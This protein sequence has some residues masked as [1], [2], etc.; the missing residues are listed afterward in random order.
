LC[1]HAVID[2]VNKVFVLGDREFSMHF[3]TKDT[4]PV[5][6][7]SLIPRAPYKVINDVIDAFSDIFSHKDTPLGVARNLPLVSIDTGDH[8]PIRQR[9]YRLPFSKRE[10]C[11]K[12]I[13]QMLREGIIRESDSPWASPVVMTPCK[14]GWH[15]ALLCRLQKNQRHHQK[16]SLSSSLGSGRL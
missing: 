2:F 4:C 11:E 7:V 14:E 8:S 15:Y 10:E 6:A 16:E 3:S 1:Q 13:Q 9:A 12:L 5:Q